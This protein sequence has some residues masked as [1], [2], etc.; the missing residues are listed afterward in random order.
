MAELVDMV[1]AAFEKDG[2]ISRELTAAGRAYSISEPQVD[3]AIAVARTFELGPNE[4]GAPVTLLEAETGTGKSFGYLVPMTIHCARAGQRGLVSTFTHALMEQLCDRELPIAVAVAESLTGQRLTFARRIGVGNF[5]S[6]D[7][8]DALRSELRFEGASR[9]GPIIG[10]LDSLAAWCDG[11]GNLADWIAVNGPLPDELQIGDLT[12]T[13]AEGAEAKAYRAHLATARRADLLIVPH[14]L[15]A[16][17]IA[18]GGRTLVEDGDRGFN[19]AVI[20][21]GDALPGVLRDVFHVHVSTLQLESL[22]K[23]VYSSQTQLAVRALVDEFKLLVSIAEERVA[24]TSRNR[25]KFLSLA[26][27]QNGDIRQEAARIAD[28]LHHLIAGYCEK[29]VEKRVISEDF[30]P[31]LRGLERFARACETMADHQAPALTWS[32]VRGVPAFEVVP[33]DSSRVA[34]RFFRLDR[35]GATMI[36]ALCITSAT[37]DAPGP[38]DTTAFRGYREQIGL[39]QKFHNYRNELSGRFSPAVFGELTFHLSRPTA[40]SPFLREDEG[41]GEALRNPHWYDYCERV[42]LQ[43][44]AR[45]ERALVLTGSYDDTAELA[46]RLRAR[47]HD[48]I[49]QWRGGRLKDTAEVFRSCEGSMWLAPNAWEGLDLPGLIKHLVIT[50]LPLQNRANSLFQM[51]YDVLRGRGLGDDDAMRQLLGKVMA[52]GRRKLKQGLGR[53]IRAASDTCEVWITDPRFP[54]PSRLLADPK[55]GLAIRYP[56][57]KAFAGCIPDRFRRGLFPAYEE[58][59]LINIDNLAELEISSDYQ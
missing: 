12:L 40:P 19:C 28:N 39:T 1:R 42:L 52:D 25:Q 36:E 35:E 26:G 21:E 44:A 33:H 16:Y 47:G 15:L 32:P 31:V 51:E 53:A 50:R 20:D 23:L 41:T 7:K 13:T 48:V 27:T 24:V 38:S 10:I 17:H 18:F 11:T 29:K 43:V 14:A 56:G 54:I 37:L 6:R 34:S 22:C 49:E 30:Q 55:L 46:A 9:A 2:P 5:L 45:R 3:Y 4:K 8:I 57:Y 59:T 58:A